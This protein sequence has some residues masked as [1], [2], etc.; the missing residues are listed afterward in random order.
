MHSTTR[1]PKES[2][3]G[4]ETVEEEAPVSSLGCH[5]FLL[6]QT[7]KT[8]LLL[9]QWA[10]LLRVAVGVACAVLLLA[11]LRGGPLCQL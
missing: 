6:V 8:T 5:A 7:S 1:L 2:M 10:V 4:Q 3:V 11:A 9:F